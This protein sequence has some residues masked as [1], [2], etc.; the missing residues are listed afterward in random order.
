MKDK[1]LS[2]EENCHYFYPITSIRIEQLRRRKRLRLPAVLR[3]RERG[4][5]LMDF[6]PLLTYLPDEQVL[7][8]L[9][10]WLRDEAF[11]LAV[12]KPR[13][14]KL[15]DFRPPAKGKRA[16]ITLNSNLGKFQFLTTLVHEIAHLKV[17]NAYGRKAAP[18]GV[19]WKKIFGDMLRE[20][21][22]CCS[23]PKE[24][25]AAILHHAARPK[26][27]V[28]GDPQLQKVVLHLDGIEGMTLLG[29]LEPGVEFSFKGR[30]FQFLEKRRTRALVLE[31]GSKNKFTI[32]LVAQVERLA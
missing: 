7:P 22:D 25:E 2:D 20:M 4:Q 9:H 31:S 15:G 18:H 5:G 6:K 27:A 11:D 19:E 17:W 1:L 16:K 8:L 29:D 23:F 24:Y 3:C 10:L 14:T 26:S 32:P 28:G 12:A 30:S 13:A 21:I